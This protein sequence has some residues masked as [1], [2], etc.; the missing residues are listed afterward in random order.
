MNNLEIIKL[1]PSQWQEYKNLRLRALKD[2]PDAFGITYEEA[3]KK[4]D[5]EWREPLELAEQGNGKWMFFAKLNGQL[6]GMISGTAMVKV[7]DGVK[8]REM[9][10]VE[11]ARGKGIA[12]KLLEALINELLENSDKRTLQLG[13]FTTQEA[14]INLYKK[15]G[16]NVLEQITEHFPSGLS[17]ESLIMEKKLS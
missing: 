5:Q 12:K 13:V 16:F 3:V 2:D 11:E 9:F 1:T 15:M 7:K 17:H 10:V 6:V 4:S 8:V 14:A